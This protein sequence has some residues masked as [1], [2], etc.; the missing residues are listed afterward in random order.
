MLGQLAQGAQ[1]PTV[2]ISEA[3]MLL[4]EPFANFRS[5]LVA[6]FS[7]KKLAV[8][9]G[10]LP[11]LYVLVYQGSQDKRLRGRLED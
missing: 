3:C 10:L 2:S 6:V 11:T 9:L 5:T 7:P 8:K 1:E 4:F